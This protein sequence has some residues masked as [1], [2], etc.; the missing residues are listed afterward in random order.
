MGL[1]HIPYQWSHNPMT[2]SMVVDCE[3]HQFV[4]LPPH[5]VWFMN[6]YSPVQSI[7]LLAV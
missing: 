3:S 6:P 5:C 4:V 7:P 1:L 2:Q